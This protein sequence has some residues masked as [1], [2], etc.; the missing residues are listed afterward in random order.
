MQVLATV[1]AIVSAPIGLG[2]AAT[3]RIVAD[4]LGRLRCR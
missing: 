3:G 2:G 4:S 1:S